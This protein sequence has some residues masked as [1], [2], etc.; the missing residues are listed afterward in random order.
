MTPATILAVRLSPECSDSLRESWGR[1]HVLDQA[2]G[3]A[4]VVHDVGREAPALVVVDLTRQADG[5]HSAAGDLELL[6]ARWPNTPVLAIV[7]PDCPEMLERR[8]VLSNVSLLRSP[9]A[10]SLL[11]QVRNLLPVEAPAPEPKRGA[12]VVTPGFETASGSFRRMLDD[13][14]VAASHNVT[15]LLIGETGS[16][17]TH[18][19]RR[20]HEASPRRDEPFLHVACGALPRELIE[21]ELFGHVRGAFTSAHADKDGK[22]VAAGRG[23]ILLD[24][25]DVLGPEQQVKLLKVIE[26]GEFEPVG[27]NRT[28]KSQ[29]RLV[30]ASNLELQPLVERGQF[31]PDLYYRLNMLKFDIPPLRKR[32]PDIVP[33]A[34]KFIEK[35]QELHGV[36]IRRVDEALFDSLLAYPWPGNVRELEHV[37]QRAVIYCRDGVLTDCCLPPHIL[38]GQAGPTNDSTVQL[39]GRFAGADPTLERQVAFTEREIIE[40][41]LYKNNFSRTNTAR[42]LGISRVTLYN[43]MKKYKMMRT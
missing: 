36:S 18:L 3:L 27:S 39:G 38:A 9:S 22:F 2:G 14:S 40:Q 12:N 35:F 30:V 37:V 21:S 1:S 6:T 32:R 13:V 7:D 33:L 28:L 19:S 31:R 16:G 15:I 10:E 26:T 4:E 11:G 8:A 42:E 5:G 23:T 17:K 43:K 41:T 20:I 25:I 34:R 24:E 29:A